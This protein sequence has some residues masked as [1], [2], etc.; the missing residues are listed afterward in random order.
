MTL[1]PFVAACIASNIV[2]TPLDEFPFGVDLGI[3]LGSASKPSSAWRDVL[4]NG[5]APP[6]EPRNRVR[7]PTNV[8]ID[9]VLR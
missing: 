8:P 5:I 3:S 9:V 2:F 4:R 1:K 6:V 7:A